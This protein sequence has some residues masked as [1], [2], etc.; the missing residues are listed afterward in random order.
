MLFIAKAYHLKHFNIIKH[1]IKQN[2]NYSNYIS[3]KSL[4]KL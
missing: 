1:V 3:L 4:L 2:N